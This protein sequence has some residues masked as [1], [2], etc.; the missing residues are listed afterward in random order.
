[1][2]ASPL[3]STPAPI[4]TTPE[5]D[6][7]FLVRQFAPATPFF[8]NT[9]YPNELISTSDVDMM[10]MRCSPEYFSWSGT[11]HEY[12]DPVTLQRRKITEPLL[13]TYLNSA[14]NLNP[15][16]YIIS[17]AVCEIKNGK[18][19]V[20]YRVGPCGGGCAGLPHLSYG[21]ADGSLELLAI[22]SPDQDGAYFGCQPLQLTK[23]QILYVTCLGEGTG[24]IRRIDLMT[25]SVSAILSC[26]DSESGITCISNESDYPTSR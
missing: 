21:Q 26:R 1:M 2:I 12:V 8:G 20:V 15:G 17:I 19:I 25:H 18:P 3:P 9:N 13:Q 24:I 5:T 11:D 6:V 23:S 14:Q 22:I 16:K 4:L 10:R 7:G